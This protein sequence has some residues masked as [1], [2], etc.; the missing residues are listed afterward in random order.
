LWDAFFLVIMTIAIGIIFG[1]YILLAA[2]TR[3]T[4]PDI[5]RKALGYTDDNEKIYDTNLGIATGAGDVDLIG[6]VNKRLKQIEEI[7]DTDVLKKIVDEERDLYRS[8]FPPILAA[9]IEENIENTGWILSY[10]T[11]DKEAPAEWPWTLRLALI[12]PSRNIIGSQHL[13]NNC[14]IMI[15]PMEANQEEADSIST[16]LNELV[17]PSEQFKT[18][19]ESIQ[20]H[21]LQIANL[22]QTMPPKYESISRNCQIG[23]HT[24][25]GRKGISA[26]VKPGDAE[27]S[28][29]LEGFANASQNGG[30]GK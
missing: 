25:D 3:V 28:I 22:I 1:D 4:H 26:V 12:H 8:R 6:N 5:N 2:D 10:V 14:P 17:K 9:Y 24:L 11:Y 18:V 13:A 27:V 30:K 16:S 15:A 21:G 7:I 23:A 20:Y 29:R 19:E